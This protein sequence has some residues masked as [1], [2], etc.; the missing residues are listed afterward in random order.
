MN[1]IESSEPIARKEHQCFM[2][3]GVIQ[4]GEKY[5]RE[6]YEEGGSAYSVKAH[7][8]CTYLCHYLNMDPHQEGLDYEVFSHWIRREF[9]EE[10]VTDI[11]VAAKQ[12]LARFTK[13]EEDH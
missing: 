4:K 6:V 13:F 7:F 8:H 5:Q 3:N 2:C 1:H 11:P 10:E 12:L 9:E